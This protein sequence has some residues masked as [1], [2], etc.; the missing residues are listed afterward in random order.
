VIRDTTPI[1][2]DHVDNVTTVQAIYES[3]GGGDIPAILDRLADDVAW[4][5]DG[6]S[7]GIPIYEPGTGKAHV[8]R[9]FDSLADLEFLRF[10]PTNLLVGGDQVAAVIE[11][12][13]KVKATGKVANLLEVHLWTFGADGKVTRFHHAVDRHAV[14][15]AYGR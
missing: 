7:H 6:Q 15:L 5:Q 9:F 1:E 3:F 4:D 13:V 2:C 10:E 12:D 8:Q 11:L 14:V